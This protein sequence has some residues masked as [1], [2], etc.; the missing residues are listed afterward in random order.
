M[1]PVVLEM[2]NP[3]IRPRHWERIFAGIGEAYDPDAA[4]TLN[5]LVKA[6]VIE[7]AEL[8]SEVSGAASGESQIEESLESVAGSWTS[9]EFVVLNHRDTPGLFILGG[10]DDIFTLLEDSSVTLQTMMGSRFIMGV[11][12][13]VEEWDKKLR[14]LSETLDEW[15]ALQRTWM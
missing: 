13:A 1:M 7:K 6:G 14:L 4:F 3:A 11:R 8:V 10:L 15:I 12:D 5:Q 2:G 9:V